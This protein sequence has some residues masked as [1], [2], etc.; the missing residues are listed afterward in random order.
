MISRGSTFVRSP[1]FSTL[2]YLSTTISVRLLMFGE[3]CHA[4]FPPF[5]SFVKSVD[6]S[7]TT[8]S[9]LWSC[10]LFIRYS[11]ISTSS[12][13]GFLPTSR[14][15]FSQSSTLRLVWCDDFVVVI[16]YI[17]YRCAFNSALA[18]PARTSGLQGCCHGVLNVAWACATIFKPVGSCRRPSRP[19]PTSLIDIILTARLISLST[20][21]YWSF[22][23]AAAIA[24]N[25]LPPD[26]QSFPSL[27]IFH[28]HLKIFCSANFS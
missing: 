13:S 21:G 26:V 24:W 4:V 17:R 2:E 7:L 14:D 20:V 5:A 25:S 27:S 8:V 16:T 11:T 1:S 6:T 9:A 19:S 15:N 22:A 10:H 28:R 12:W 18:A 23:V 3:L